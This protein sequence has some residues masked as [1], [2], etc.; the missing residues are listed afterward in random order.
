MA[1]M[2]GEQP[3]ANDDED[4]VCPF[5]GERGF[6]LIGLKAHLQHGD[7]EKFESLERLWRPW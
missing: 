3:S 2:K 5:C 6:D 1:E 7:C 4:R